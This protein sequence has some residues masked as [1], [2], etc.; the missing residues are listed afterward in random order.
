[1]II[2]S[3]GAVHDEH[4]EQHQQR[5]EVH[6]VPD[7][8][9]IDDVD[10]DELPEVAVLRLAVLLAAIGVV[11]VA[12]LCVGCTC[13]RLR[14]R[15]AGGV[16][17]TSDDAGMEVEMKPQRAQRTRGAAEARTV[18]SRMRNGPRRGRRGCTRINESDELELDNAAGEDVEDMLDAR[19][20][21]ALD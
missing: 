19:R 9:K 21:F 15:R 2:I 17:S 20:A 16:L 11:P 18:L 10:Y 7:H 13:R 1:M 14:R 5:P 6:P 3:D 8:P 12:G 4:D